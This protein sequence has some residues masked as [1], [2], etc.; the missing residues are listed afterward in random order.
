MGLR[1][2]Y[3]FENPIFVKYS[4]IQAPFS[5]GVIS[6]SQATG[7][8]LNQEQHAFF[9]ALLLRQLFLLGVMGTRTGVGLKFAVTY[10]L[11]PVMS[12][13]SEPR[14]TYLFEIFL[15]PFFIKAINFF[16]GS[17]YN[18]N[19]YCRQAFHLVINIILHRQPR[20]YVETAIHRH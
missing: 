16:N 11:V 9:R 18:R 20:K 12:T 19:V 3:S 15:G 14:R 5:S 2:F 7:C 4:I 13:Q 17:S 6:F 10:C 8:S 1:F